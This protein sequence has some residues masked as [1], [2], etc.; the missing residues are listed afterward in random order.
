VRERKGSNLK[1]KPR[2][3]RNRKTLRKVRKLAGIHV[4]FLDVGKRQMFRSLNSDSEDYRRGPEKKAKFKRRLQCF[5][6]TPKKNPVK[7]RHGKMA[8]ENCRFWGRERDEWGTTRE[9]E[10]KFLGGRLR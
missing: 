4:Q 1:G 6:S 3:S 8:K 2:E 10:E 9:I 5:Q 7:P